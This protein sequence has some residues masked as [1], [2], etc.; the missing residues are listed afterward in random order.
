MI[1][2]RDILEY[3]NQEFQDNKQTDCYLNDYQV[4]FFMDNIYN[5]DFKYD[6]VQ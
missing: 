2:N 3:F 4:L 6:L 1:S 5:I